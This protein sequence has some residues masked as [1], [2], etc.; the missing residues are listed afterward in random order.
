M[1]AYTKEGV[2]SYSQ[3]KKL[4]GGLKSPTQAIYSLIYPIVIAQVGG[5][6]WDCTLQY[7]GK[8]IYRPL[9][10]F[11]CNNFSSCGAYFKYREVCPVLEKI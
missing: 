8:I 5:G 2:D 4:G 7:T 10:Y 11:Y 9:R 1:S 3:H 6:G